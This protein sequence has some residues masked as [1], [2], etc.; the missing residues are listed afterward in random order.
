MKLFD[1][2]LLVDE[3]INIQVV[4]SLVEKGKN[5]STVAGEGLAGRDDVDVLRHAHSQ[6]RV[7]ITHDSDFGALATRAGEPFTGIVYL[8]PGHSSPA[9]V[10]EMIQELELIEADIKT[11]F[12]IVA[13]RR[14]DIMRVRLRLTE[15]DSGAIVE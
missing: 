8:R 14:A 12:I 4:K 5:V 11:P 9:F 7:V 1:Y 13:E 3:N 15:R 6:N 10:I 2:P